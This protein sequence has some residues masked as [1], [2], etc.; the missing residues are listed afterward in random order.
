MQSI[1]T[2]GI[3]NIKSKNLKT[4][5][6]NMVPSGGMFSSTALERVEASTL[7]AKRRDKAFESR[8]DRT[9][10]PSGL[11]A[12]WEHT[13]HANVTKRKEE[14]VRGAILVVLQAGE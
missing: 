1:R 11:N 8:C 6:L 5:F 3:L 13:R 9:E 2:R 4:G 7:V 14:E 12:L 10:T